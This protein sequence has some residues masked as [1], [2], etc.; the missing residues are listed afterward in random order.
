M[1][2]PAHFAV[3]SPE[4]LHDLIARHPLGTLVTQAGGGLDANHLPFALS[5][6]SGPQG[7]LLAHVARANP[8]WREVADGDPVLVI[9]RAEQ[10]YIS[11]N[12]YPSKHETHRQVPTWNYRVVH[13]HGHIRVRDDVRFVRGV[14]SRLTHDHED[15]RPRPWRMADAPQDY[16]DSMLANIVGI[17]VEISRL[18]GKFKLSQ[19]RETRDIR[20]AAEAL[21]DEGQEALAQ[22]MRDII[23]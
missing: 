13:V 14:V 17:E 10:A 9:F 16:L 6:G 3:S 15:V 22:R 4:A 5:P 1:Y 20:G 8:L 2:V 21:A 11:P 12:W 19:N 7:V 23:V 18:E